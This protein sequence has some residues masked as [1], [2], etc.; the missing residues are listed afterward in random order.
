MYLYFWS[1]FQWIVAPARRSSSRG[2][3]TALHESPF[4][5][6]I[7]GVPLPVHMAKLFL[8]EKFTARQVHIGDKRGTS[9]QCLHDQVTG[10]LANGVFSE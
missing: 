8:S 4:P 9:S 6:H 7:P 3:D 1:E 10:E 5:S 2:E